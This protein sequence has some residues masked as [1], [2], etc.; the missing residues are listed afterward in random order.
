[1]PDE[2]LVHAVLLEFQRE[3]SLVA[4]YHC[5]ATM[6]RASEG[7]TFSRVVVVNAQGK[8]V[9][10]DAPTELEALGRALMQQLSAQG[11][12]QSPINPANRSLLC[13]R[14]GAAIMNLVRTCAGGTRE[15]SEFVDEVLRLEEQ[16][17]QPAGLV[18]T[19]TDTR[20]G[21]TCFSLHMPGTG[22]ICASFECR[23]DTGEFR[24]TS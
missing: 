11:D 12:D 16:A 15:V 14:L 10:V 2:D 5:I 23:L 18:L 19:A 6:V 21:W 3:G 24:R 7:T 1:M 17:I 22:E 8:R 9:L 13:E 20:D 4:G